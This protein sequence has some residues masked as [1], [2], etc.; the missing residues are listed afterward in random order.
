MSF[1]TSEKTGIALCI[2][3]AVAVEVKVYG[4][5]IISSP[6]LTPT[7]TTAACRAEVAELNAIACLIPM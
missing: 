5:T 3:A 6:G 7:L 2:K 1:F 4:G